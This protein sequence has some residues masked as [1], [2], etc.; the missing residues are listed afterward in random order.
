MAQSFSIP[1]NRLIQIDKASTTPVYMQIANQFSNAIQRNIIPVQT[2]L[3]GSRKLAELLGVNRNT[4]IAAFDELTTQGWLVSYPNQ[5]TFVHHPR[6]QIHSNSHSFPPTTGYTFRTDNRLDL[7]YDQHPCTY[8]FTDGTPDIRL[9]FQEELAA[10]FSANLKRK[11]HSTYFDPYTKK[12]EL[13][14][15]KQVVNYLNVTRNIQ[16]SP[17]NLVTTTSTTSA[18][19]L[20][21]RLLLQAGDQVAITEYSYYGSNVI[22]QHTG[23][24]LHPIPLL[25]EGIDLDALEKLCQQIPLRLVYL[26]VNHQYPTTFSLPAQQRM[27]L[28]QL[29]QHYGFILLEDDVNFDFHYNH[30]PPL[31]LLSGDTKGMVIYLSS[32]GKS[33]A[34][35][36]TTGIIVAPENLI[37]ELEK[38]KALLENESNYFTAHTLAEL[39]DEGALYRHQVKVNKIYKERRDYCCEVLRTLWGDSIDFTVPEG[40]LAVWITFRQ[41]INLMRVRTFCM[42]NNLYIPTTLLYQSKKLTGMR[43]GFAHLSLEELEHCLS[44]FHQACLA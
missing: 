35:D 10:I 14:F 32:I 8:Y 9:G 23:A 3:P 40:D 21:V 11:Q 24:Q 27:K 12:A 26:S 25:Q 34:P 43:L 17:A 2:K 31:P 6:Q 29:A 33:L 38:H 41:P 22:L 28:L 13:R 19:S 4:I 1:Y 44:I 5:G 15:K 36:F 16:A 20:C 7:P 42:L 39:I 18:L 30:T 37:A